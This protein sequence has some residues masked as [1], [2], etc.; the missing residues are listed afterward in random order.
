MRTSAA[1]AQLG[2]PNRR[3]PRSLLCALLERDGPGA[4]G[5]HVA[6]M[7]DGALIDSRVLMAHRLGADDGAWPTPEDRFAS[8]LLLAYRIYDHWLS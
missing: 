6:A 1:G 8:Y 5:R 2:R 4:L 3:P 7:S